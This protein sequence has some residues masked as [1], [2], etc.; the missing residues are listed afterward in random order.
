LK[1]LIIAPRFPFPLEK[2]DKLRLYHQ[3]RN[4]HGK[5]KITLVAL[6]DVKPDQKHYEEIEKY[7]DKI[8]V[9][10]LKKINII[11]EN[12]FSIFSDKPFQ[13]LY[14][15]NKKIHESVRQVIHRENPDIVYCQ[16]VRSAEYARDYKG[17]KVLDYMDAFSFGMGKRIA[18]SP[19]WMKWFYFVEQKRLQKYEQEIFSYFDAHT[20]I[21]EQDKNRILP[22]KNQTV[23]VI[24][25]GVDTDFFQ[26]FFSEK[27]FD[28][29]FV[30]NMGYRPNIDAVVYL[31]KEIVPELRKRIPGIRVLLAGARPHKRVLALQNECTTVT[32]WME[33]IREAYAS[34]KIFVAPIFTGIGQQNKVLEAMSM[35]MPCVCT[36]MVNHPIGSQPG[37]E[38]FIADDTA[39]FAVHIERLLHDPEKAARVG[40][41]ARE[42][43]HNQYAWGK[44][45]DKLVSVFSEIIPSTTNK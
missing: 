8:Y 29:C 27:K 33:D 26:P 14:F 24:P 15:Y 44:Q 43:V 1:V 45:I 25:N 36:T 12:L 4:L 41:L 32:G 18:G 40:K 23:R 13:V 6:S 3:I 22:G 39:D 10:R 21:S 7:T 42:F 5:V 2:G 31:C 19:V 11:L 16:L 37:Q 20:I 35:E 28:I 30:G 34:S 17:V 38:V 9:F